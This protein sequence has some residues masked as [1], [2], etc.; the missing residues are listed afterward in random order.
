M[1]KT[2]KLKI[3]CSHTWVLVYFAYTYISLEAGCEYEY[4]LSSE[5]ISQGET[6]G[7]EV[8]GEIRQ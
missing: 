5:R 1:T 8:A 4:R 3:E 2:R 7:V 6:R